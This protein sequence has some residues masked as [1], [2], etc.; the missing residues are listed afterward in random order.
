MFIIM[1][2][3]NTLHLLKCIL[4][5][6]QPI[7]QTS[8]NEQKS[9]LKY[10]QHANA[11]AEIGVFEGFNTRNFAL[12]SPGDAVIYAIDPFIKGFFGLCYGKLIAQNDWKKNK[13]KNKI[14]VVQGLSWDVASFI[15]EPL[16]FIFIDGDHSFD[17]VTKDFEL[18]S[19]KLS[20]TGTIAFHDSRIFPK[21]WTGLEW[22]P[23][24]FI[25]K[26]IRQDKGWEIVEE[27]DSIVFI[28]RRNNI[29]E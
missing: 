23:V 1:K 9:M 22:E 6:E 8:A 19:Q 2:G 29:S 20:P 4:N 10:V 16:D 12:N 27:T 15:R 7:T 21:G 5:I 28:Q 17:A 14:K 25:D 24:Q 11:I 26:V 18:Y 13:I 3:E